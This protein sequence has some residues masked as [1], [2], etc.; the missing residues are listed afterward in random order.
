MNT[1]PNDKPILVMAYKNRALDHFIHGCISPSPSGSSVCK[2]QDIVRIGHTAEGYGQLEDTLLSKK[3]KQAM[4]RR[5]WIE[6]LQKLKS[7]YKR[8]IRCVQL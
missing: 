7:L 6:H 4:F 1:L 8:Y 3:V 2:L 5:S